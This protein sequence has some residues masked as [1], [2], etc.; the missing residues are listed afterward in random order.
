MHLLSSDSAR[1]LIFFLPT[2]LLLSAFQLSILSEVRLGLKTFTCCI[3]M[4]FVI[5]I[6]FLPTWYNMTR[7][8]GQKTLHLQVS[9][10]A[11][12]LIQAGENFGIPQNGEMWV[13]MKWQITI[14]F[15]LVLSWLIHF[16]LFLYVFGWVSTFCRLSNSRCS[17]GRK[18]FWMGNYP[19]PRMAGPSGSFIG[20]EK[21][22]F[23]RRADLFTST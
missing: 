9:A 15:L 2:W 17:I 11:Q 13:K 16:I 5:C 4:Y 18:Y 20:V 23:S 7:Q 21:S 8:T 1:V 14:S 6:G 10:S 22:R 19:P 3:W 12:R